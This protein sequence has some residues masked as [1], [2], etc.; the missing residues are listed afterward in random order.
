MIRTLRIAEEV[1]Y[2]FDHGSKEKVGELSDEK[3]QILGRALSRQV[4]EWKVSLPPGV[5]NIG[6]IKRSYYSVRAYM[7]EVGLYGLLQG[8]APS[9]ARVSIIYDC[10]NSTMKYLSSVLECPLDEMADWTALDWRSLNFIIMLST[11]SSIILDSAYVSTEA[12]QRA[13]WLGKCLDTLCLRAQEL[14]R[15]KT[16]SCS[17]FQKISTEWANMKVYH[18]NCLQRSLPSSTAANGA[19]MSTQLATQEHQPCHVPYV[20]NAFDLDP[21]NELFWA[22]FADSEPGL[23]GVF[24]M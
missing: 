12:S 11:K 24:P 16:E 15:L 6:R 1:T 23:G 10:F 2:T 5:F 8:Q 22:G 20:D 7:R 18:Q 4:D 14:H 21:F 3:I 19:Q 9:V 13:A 17:Y